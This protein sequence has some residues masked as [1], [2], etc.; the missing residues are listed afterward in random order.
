MPQPITNWEVIRA[1]GKWRFIL[2]RG[3]EVGLG[4]FLLMLFSKLLQFEPLR[5]DAIAIGLAL[6]LTLG[7][8]MALVYWHIQERR[9]RRAL[10]Q[11]PNN[12]PPAPK[13]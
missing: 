13:A 2:M 6:W 10:N 9:Y 3:G 4:V 1:Q 11:E 7:P 12:Q 5:L 8:L